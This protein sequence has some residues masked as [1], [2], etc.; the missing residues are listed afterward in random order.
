MIFDIVKRAYTNLPD[1]LKPQTKTDT[2]RMLRFTHRFDGAILDS[3]IY[4]ALKL[5]SGT[6]QKLHITE[7]AFNKDRQ[8]LKAGSMQ[9]VPI[10]G[11]ISEETTANGFNEFYDDYME[12]ASKTK[13]NDLDYKAY[14]YA[15]FENPEYTLPGSIDPGEKTQNEVGI[16]SK[17]GLSDGQ[18]L[19]RRWKISELRRNQTG[20]GLS[21]EQLFKQEYPATMLEAFQSGAGH[22]FDPERL[23]NCMPKEPLTLDEIR[24]DLGEL[25]ENEKLEEM[26]KTAESLHN[27]GVDMWKVPAPGKKYVTG[28]DPSDGEG[29]DYSDIDVWD[30]D[31]LEQVAQYYVK[32]RPDETAE[33]VAEIATYYNK[34]FVGVE[35]NMLSTILFLSKIYDNYYFENRI[36]EKTT[37]RTKKIGWNT[38]SKTRDV[39]IDEF[40]IFFDDG[41]LIINSK[42]TLSEMK[43]FVKK[44]N[45]KREH[46][47]GK[48]DDALFGGFIAIQMRKFDRPTA[49]VFATKPF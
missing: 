49:R 16:Q 2:V 48:H 21:G 24:R 20:L 26:I 40:N 1:E 46:A 44:D 19:W 11:T 6:V 39:M 25:Y 28:V 17:Y 31:T 18:L 23:N 41:N 35:N 5:R 29:A 30:R 15:W 47:D 32:L 9:A 14:F 42:R 8:E 13:W 37:K 34:A 33:A 45:G 27:K 43:T 10:T 22:V 4:V 3:M 38:N 7:S 36:D 12:A